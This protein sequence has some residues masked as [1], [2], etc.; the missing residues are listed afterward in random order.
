MSKQ[1]TKS[2]RMGLALLKVCRG[3]ALSS[4]AGAELPASCFGVK[5]VNVGPFRKVKLWVLLRN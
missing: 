2:V 3:R 5:V 4:D 1:N